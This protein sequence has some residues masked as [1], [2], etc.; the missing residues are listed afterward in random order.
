MNAAV[1]TPRTVPLIGGGDA[2]A[3]RISVRA[4]QD[5]L[6]QRFAAKACGAHPV[7]RPARELARDLIAAV[8]DVPRY[9]P[10][11]QGDVALDPEML[12][13]VEDAAARL[14]RGMPFA[15]AVRRASFRTLSLHV[16]ERVLIPR[17]ETE[18]LVD[19][20]LDELRRARPG[21]GRGQTPPDDWGVALDVGT[22]SGCIALALAVE[23]KFARVIG[24]DVSGDALDVARRNAS[25]CVPAATSARVEFRQGSY[26]TPFAVSGGGAEDRA[27]VV[28]SNPPYIAWD[29]QDALPRSVRDWEP[30]L[31]LFA[32][33][34]GLAAVGAVAEGALGALLP[35]GLLVMEVDSRRAGRASEL[36][37]G[38][39]HGGDAGARFVDVVVR[40]DLTGRARFVVARRGRA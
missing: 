36:V 19:I 31:A 14:E 32:S 2:D 40:P 22:G 3:S 18:L 17:P 23:G 13:A 20:V 15:Y 39:R 1:A 5:R 7:P 4:V 28:V 29:E 9:W 27:T 6:A 24:T 26:L 33:D 35:G 25:L 16:D 11:T 10:M 12:A 8:L 34:E 37:L 21:G 38:A 30:A